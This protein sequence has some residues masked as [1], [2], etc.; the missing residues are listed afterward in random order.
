MKHIHHIIPKHMGGTDDPSNLVEL[1]IEE[2]AAAHK[3][4]W[5]EYGEEFDRLAYLSLSGQIGKEEIIQ[6]KLKAASARSSGN[7]GRKF[8]EE[9]KENIGKASKKKWDELKKNGYD[10]GQKLRGEKNG[11]YGRKRTEEEKK[12]MSENRK[13]KGGLKGR[14]I[15]EEQ[16]RRQSEAMKAYWA[17]RKEGLTK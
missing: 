12:K 7:T 1:T 16:K 14:V 5:E 11:M 13:G 10:H 9:W 17:R 2:H 4:L 6:M 3:K 8:S 15:S